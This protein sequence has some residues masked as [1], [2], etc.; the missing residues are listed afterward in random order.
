MQLCGVLLIVVTGAVL[1]LPILFVAAVVAAAF[2]AGLAAMVEDTA[3]RDRFGED[4]TTYRLSV[5]NW[6][7]RWRPSSVAAPARVYVAR[8]CDPCSD[9][10]AWIGDRS[11][12][13]L[14]VRAAEEHPEQLRRIRYEQAAPPYS[15]DG[16]KAIG[17]VMTHLNLAWAVVGWVISTPVVAPFLQLLVDASG[18]GPR[19]LSTAPTS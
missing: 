5:R 7:P 9:V 19:D 15:V 18:G 4:W 13:G 12:V 14:D 1:S 3:L 2:S 16:V 17:A 6:I 8:G 11:P 10:A